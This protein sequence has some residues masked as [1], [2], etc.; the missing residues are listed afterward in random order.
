MKTKMAKMTTAEKINEIIT[1]LEYASSEADWGRVDEA[2]S[3]LNE[4]YEEL[5]SSFP[6]DEYDED[7]F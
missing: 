1:L 5:T 2:I 3:E 6:M 7:E 4:L